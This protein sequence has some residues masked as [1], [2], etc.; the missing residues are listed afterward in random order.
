MQMEELPAGFQENF[1]GVGNV[2][3]KTWFLKDKHN[4]SKYPSGKYFDKRIV[5]FLLY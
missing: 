3:S 1:F 5:I 4:F 2:F